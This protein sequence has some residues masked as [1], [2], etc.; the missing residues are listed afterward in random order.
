MDSENAANRRPRWGA[1]PGLFSVN[2][3]IIG[4]AAGGLNGLLSVGGGIVIVP[5]LIFLRKVNIRVAVATSLGTVLLMS[6][7]ALGG[8]LLISGFVMSP[9][10]T[11][12]LIL[13]GVAGARVGAWLLLRLP[14]R[15]IFLLFAGFTVLA[16]S[17]LIALAFGFAPPV[18][19]D[20]PPLWSYP[21]IGFV[22]GV[23]SG[24]LGL[25]GGGLAVLAFSI[26]FHTPVLSGLPVALALN[27]TNS[28]A[29]VV[30]QSK[31]KLVLWGAVW[32]MFPAA[33]LGV[34]VGVALAVVLP[35]DALRVVFAAFYL[36]VGFRMLRRGLRS[37]P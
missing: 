10:G 14:Q 27:V 18:M 5:G 3:A 34:G 7:A 2:F 13:A 12:L 30:L 37:D 23:F 22:S 21:A 11:G 19:G 15:T 24:L 31:Q 16:S 36:I 25:G 8:H 4:F 33:L 26:L 17:H 32:R 9:A 29:G 1:L 28:L 35:P 6:L 20:A